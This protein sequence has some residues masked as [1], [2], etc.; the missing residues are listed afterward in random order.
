MFK[1]QRKKFTIA[2]IGEVLWDIYREQRYLGGAPANVAIHAAQLGEEGIVISRIGNDGL[3]NELIRALE[4]K[5]LSTR[6]VQLDK[7]KGTG[8]VFIR[9]DVRGVP[10]FICNDDMAFDYLQFTPELEKLAGSVDAVV[11]GTLAQRN[12]VSRKTIVSFL[13]ACTGVRVFDINARSGGRQLAEIVTGVLPFTDILKVSEDE[14]RLLMGA[15]RHEGEK[16]SGFARELMQAY[17]VRLVA[18]TR[19]SAGAVVITPES[20]HNVPGHPIQVVDTTGAGDAFTAGLVHKYLH[21]ADLE[22]ML[23]FANKMAAYVCMHRGA[24]PKLS[25]QTIEQFNPE[26]GDATS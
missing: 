9:L 3:G 6:Y 18:I 25:L 8:A 21:Q 14:M 12:E 17:P 26:N 19:G 2:G 15:L 24:T 16:F 20:I 10:S 5:H 1:A 13:E 7:R 11:F 23:A 4:R 22:A